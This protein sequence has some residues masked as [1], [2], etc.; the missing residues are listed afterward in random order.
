MSHLLHVTGLIGQ[1]ALVGST[2]HCV[3][4]CCDGER[5]EDRE[6]RKRKGR[7]KEEEKKRTGRGQAEKGQAE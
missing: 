6:E 2:E 1:R 4:L 3:A 7:G 5:R